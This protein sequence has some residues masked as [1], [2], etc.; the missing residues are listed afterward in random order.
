MQGQGPS[1]MQLNMGFG[2]IQRLEQK[3][4]MTP[5]LK[6]EVSPE[7]VKQIVQL[8]LKKGNYSPSSFF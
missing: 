4:V 5:R 3:L 2:T 6:K 8:P 7:E 1:K